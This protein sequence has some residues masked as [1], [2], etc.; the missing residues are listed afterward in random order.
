MTS[1]KLLNLSLSRFPQQQESKTNSNLVGF[2]HGANKCKV[3][4]IAQV[5][6]GY[7]VTFN[8]WLVWLGGDQNAGVKNEGVSGDPERVRC[9]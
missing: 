2:P 5:R 7:A 4:E 3:F 6:S 1:S 8:N 9:R